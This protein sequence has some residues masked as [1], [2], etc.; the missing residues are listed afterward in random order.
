VQEQKKSK[1]MLKINHGLAYLLLGISGTWL[2]TSCSENKIVQC[3]KFAQVNDKVRVSL[4]KHSENGQ[5]LGKK[6]SQDLAGFKELAKEMSQHLSQSA[7]GIDAALQ[8]IEGLNVQD[9]K[10]K[11]FKNEYISIT[12]SIG[13]STQELSKISSTQSQAT[14]IDLKNGSLQKLGQNFDTISQKIAASGD[15]E[16]KLMD[17][18]N[19]YCG[20]SKQKE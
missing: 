18:F 10:L 17:N 12:K 9:E 3:N 11:S 5:A 14:E 19:A 16:K 2:L 4:A 1:I 15:D 6:T 13:E 20:G 7:A 8:I